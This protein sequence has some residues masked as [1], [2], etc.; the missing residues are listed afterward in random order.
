MNAMYLELELSAQ[1]KDYDFSGEIY[2]DGNEIGTFDVETTE[3]Y[4]VSSIYYYLGDVKYKLTEKNDFTFIS[5]LDKLAYGL[6]YEGF[7]I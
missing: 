3:K 1:N 6:D 4:S 7:A 2:L 5:S